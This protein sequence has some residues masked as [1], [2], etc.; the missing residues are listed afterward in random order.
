MKPVFILFIL[1]MSL[2]PV[3]AFSQVSSVTLSGKIKEK[4]SSSFMPY[5]NVILKKSVDTSFVSGAVSDEEGLFTISG[6]KPGNY[7]LEVSYI[8][9]HKYFQPIYVGASSEF[10]NLGVITLDP[11][12]EE[13][14]V[15]VVQG[16]KDEVGGKMDKKSFETK[17]MV[18]QSGGTILQ[19]LQNL[20]G[21]SVQDGKI[22]LRGNDNVVILIDGK[23]TAL[24]GFG[25]QYG[26][27]NIPVSAIER[28]EIINN[29]SAKFDANGNAGIINI[30]LKKEKKE[31]FSGKAGMSAG[32]GALWVRKENLP[33]IRPQYVRTPK[34]NPSIQMNYRKKNINLFFQADYL[35]T[36]TLNSN[37]FVTRTYDDGTIINQQTKRNRNTHFLTS[38]LGIDWDLSKH[39]V[40]SISGMFG[41]EKILDRGDEPFFNGV[42]QEN[43]RL[44]QFLEDELKTTA[45][46]IVDYRHAFAQAGHT[47]NVS[48]NYTFH[49]ENEQ[50]FF[51]NIYPTYT[52]HD[53]FK[54]LSDEQV[55]D[56]KIDYRKPL[57]YGRLESGVKFRFR[58]IPT[59]MQFYPGLNSPLDS[60]AGGWANYKETIPALYG[61]YVFERRKFEAELGLRVEYVKVNYD[62]NPNHPTYKSNGYD[63]LQPFPNM[64]V[65]YKFSELTRL[66]LFFNRRVDRPK[67]VDIRIFPKY[68]DAEIIK[69]GNPA[70][71]PQFTNSL[72]L[73]FKH[74]WKSGYFYGALFHRSTTGTITRIA[75][76]VPGST[77]IY[78]VYQNA[79]ESSNDGIECIW[80]QKVRKWYSFNLSLTGYLNQIQSFSVQNEYP[81]KVLY[82]SEK[83]ST[84]SGNIK[85]N[86]SFQLGEKSELQAT[87]IYLAPDI[88]PQGKMDARFTMNLGY[89][90]HIQDGKGEL[91]VNA[92]DLFNSLVIRKTIQGEGFQYTS[93]NYYETQVVRFGYSRRF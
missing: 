70:L 57:R 28:I 64:R 43:L 44:W 62:V 40:L 46:G 23:Q 92:S 11:N 34:L 81:V 49:R 69:V 60:N 22:Q 17:D 73:G 85:L 45:M 8:G 32:L 53:A 7:F 35:Y 86:N 41:T 48:F 50:Y 56:L 5:V 42:T 54:L 77:L 4:D 14:K 88:I 51:D 3:D 71:Q 20:P 55:A 25:G 61:N 79:G 93:T 78:A 1:F 10:L 65:A 31:G 13:L 74:A 30:I 27:D 47:L 2:L 37:E 68:D 90:K 15:A 91:F 89:K 58:N 33:G 67:E 66:S 63:Y 82:T 29:P 12:I 6:I 18:T 24:T 21:V 72:E 39:D 36:H 16:Q 19:A 87:L 84:Y 59:D 9:Y 75:S 38:R 52:G 26:L 80:S 76:V 83:Q